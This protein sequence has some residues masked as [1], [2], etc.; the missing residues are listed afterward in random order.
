MEVLFGIRDTVMEFIGQHDATCLYVIFALQC[1][2]V[3]LGFPLLLSACSS[4]E[5][6][7][8]LSYIRWMAKWMIV[9]FVGKWMLETYDIVEV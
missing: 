8:N 6:R 5:K 4:T 1:C 2:I 7:Y 9:T 3:F